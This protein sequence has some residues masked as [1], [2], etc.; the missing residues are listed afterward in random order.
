MLFLIVSHCLFF[1]YFSAGNMGH[2]AS[3]C[4]SKTGECSKWLDY[5]QELEL[6]VF[7]EPF[8]QLMFCT[9]FRRF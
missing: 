9:I 8:T 4:T 6:N 5:Y 2:L 1:S 3:N 7:S